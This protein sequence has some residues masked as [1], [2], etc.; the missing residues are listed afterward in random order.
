MF[1]SLQFAAYL[2]YSTECLWNILVPFCP[3]HPARGSWG[4][5]VERPSGCYSSAELAAI[6]LELCSLTPS[7]STAPF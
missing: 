7:P 2:V 5:G 4:V 6:P 3:G 1:G